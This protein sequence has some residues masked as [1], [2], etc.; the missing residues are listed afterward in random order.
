MGRAIPTYGTH[1]V[2]YP[3]L[4]ISGPTNETTPRTMPKTSQTRNHIPDRVPN[5]QARNLQRLKKLKILAGGRSYP[6]L[7]DTP[8]NISQPEQLGTNRRDHTPDRA[9]DIPKPK[10]ETRNLQ[11]L[12]IL[13]DGQSYPNLR[14]ASRNISQPEQLG[15]NRR[16]NTPNRAPDIPKPKPETRLQKLKI[17]A[18]GQSYPN[19]RDAPRNIS[20]PVHFGP[21]KR[22]HTPYHAQDIPNPKPHPRPRPQTAS[23]KP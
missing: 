7:R 5:S 20:Q 10:P 6:N 13:A 21:N 15:T 19:L 22:D 23:P 14:D 4:R 2:I 9:P 8:R 3:N 17:L 18:G 16:D 11:K 12:K 1:P